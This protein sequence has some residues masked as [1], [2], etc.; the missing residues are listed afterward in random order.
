MVSHAAVP[1]APRRLLAIKLADL[2][3]VL[4]ITPALRALRHSFPE[5]HIDVLLNPH[6][7][8]LLQN[9]ALANRVMVFPKVQYE[10]LNVLWPW[11]WPGLIRYLS[12]LRRQGYDTV[13]DFHHLTTPLGRLKQRLLIAATGAKTTVGLDNGHGRWFTHAVRDDGFGAMPEVGYWLALARRLGAESTDVSL[14]LPVAPQDEARVAQMLSAADLRQGHFVVLHPGSGG[15]S[16]ARRWEPAKFAAVAAALWQRWHLPAVV[17]GGPHDDAGAVLDR[18]TSPMTDF[19]RRTSLGELTALLRA[20]ALFV[21]ADSG[22]MHMAAAMRTPVVA[23]FGPSN[24]RAWA[25]WTPDG[26]SEVVRLGISCSPC[27]Y[28]QHS[29]AWRHG[30]PERTCLADLDAPPVVAAADRLLSA[31]LS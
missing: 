18:A 5:A 11:K 4:N 12:M 10:G 20:A 13:V 14:D 1:P 15:F 23:I 27:A 29:V 7:T 17:V 30:C 2:G 16:L 19:S 26:H 6:T 21:G 28:V 22:V 25:P 24:H 3:D 8:A 9:S 31:V